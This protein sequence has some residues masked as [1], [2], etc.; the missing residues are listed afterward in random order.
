[1]L[2]P[3]LN[4]PEVKAARDEGNW[5]LWLELLGCDERHLR[6]YLEML[7]D[8]RAFPGVQ[9]KDVQAALRSDEAF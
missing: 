6:E 9:A 2:G 4:D 3:K 8:V 5:T 1:M 7:M